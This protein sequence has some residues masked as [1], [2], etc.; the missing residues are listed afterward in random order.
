[1]TL[2]IRDL[3]KMAAAYTAAWN[4]GSADAVASHYAEAGRIVINRGT[5][6]EGR[7]GVT[8][9]A[10]GFLRD[11]PDLSL[12]CDL[13]RLAGSHAIYVWTF[14]G[15][16]AESGNPLT[17]HGWEEWELDADMKVTQ[18]YGWFDADDYARQAAGK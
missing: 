3:E 6:W 17:I 5:P 10:H 16:D 13:V 7:A 12:T 9:M 4:A 8:E 15:H 14:T 11:V 18:S 1:M 2:D